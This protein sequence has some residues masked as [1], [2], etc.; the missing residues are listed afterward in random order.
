MGER[1]GVDQNPVHL[2]AGLMDPIDEG[3]LVVALKA[4]ELDAQRLRFCAQPLLDGIEGVGAVEPRLT[5]SQQIEVGAV[6]QQQMHRCRPGSRSTAAIVGRVPSGAP[7]AGK[8]L[9]C[10][11]GRCP[12]G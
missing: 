11:S 3:S 9:G 4:T 2:A 5:L 8:F 1:S 6:Q 12:S 10:G 7:P